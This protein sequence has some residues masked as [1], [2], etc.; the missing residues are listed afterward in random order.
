MYSRHAV[1]MGEKLRTGPLWVAD[2]NLDILDFLLLSQ[3]QQHIRHKAFTDKMRRGGGNVSSVCSVPRDLNNRLSLCHNLNYQLPDELPNRK[4]VQD[5]V[6]ARS[7]SSV[8]GPGPILVRTVRS[9]EKGP[10]P[11]LVRPV[12]SSEKG[13][14][15]TLVRP[16]RSSEKGMGHTLVRPVRRKGTGPTLGRTVRSSEKGAGQSSSSFIKRRNIKSFQ[17]C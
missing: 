9:S 14:G 3:A 7:S 8:K 16:V 6:F 4:K 12:R 2:R 17:K 5:C 11:T 10:G 15:P 1:V 13:M